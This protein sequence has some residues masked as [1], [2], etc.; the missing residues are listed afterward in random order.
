MKS[1]EEKKA[2][3]A[4]AHKRWRE[5]EKGKSYYL[6]RKLQLNG[7]SEGEIWRPA[8]G[9]DGA[10]E[11]SNLGRVKS[12][13]KMVN[14]PQGIRE[15]KTRIMKPKAHSKG[16]QKVVL[17]LAGKIDEWLVHRLVLAAFEGPC[18][19]GKEAAHNNGVRTDNRLSNL[20]YATKQENMDDQIKHGT[21]PWGEQHHASKLTL[22]Q[23]D[24][25]RQS[26]EPAT[27]IAAKH[28]VSDTCISKIRNGVNWNGV[29]ERK[30]ARSDVQATSQ[31]AA[32]E[33]VK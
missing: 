23:V 30:S 12:L 5:S 24:E 20:R 2:A 11:V 15:T 16:Y 6:K 29:S 21:R 19:D 3:Q 1:P 4:A 27:V 26:S 32:Q 8:P 13:P 28:G 33:E 25:I 7:I 17:R 14:C 18:P 22:A 31:E 10:Y 9:W